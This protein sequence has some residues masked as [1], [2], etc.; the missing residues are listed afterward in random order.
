M[1]IYVFFFEKMSLLVHKTGI[2]RPD[3]TILRIAGA[4]LMIVAITPVI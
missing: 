2:T 3:S 1:D 4:S